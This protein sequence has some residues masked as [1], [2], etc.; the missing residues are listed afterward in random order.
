MKDTLIQKSNKSG[1]IIWAKNYRFTH[2]VL[3]SQNVEHFG[4]QQAKTRQLV[5][6]RQD[7]PSDNN[8]MLMS[9]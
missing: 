9:Q 5:Y 7:V 6:L 1:G 8:I 4:T 3:R 2:V